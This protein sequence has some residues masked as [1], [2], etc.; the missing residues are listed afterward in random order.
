LQILEKTLPFS[1]FLGLQRSSLRAVTAQMQTAYPLL[2]ESKV[3]VVA[4]QAI[5]CIWKLNDYALSRFHID[6][7][8]NP[9]KAVEKDL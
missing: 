3:G 4:V 2:N 7:G 1:Q 8:L 5:F 9:L 6:R